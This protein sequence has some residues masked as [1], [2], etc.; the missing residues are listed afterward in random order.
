MKKYKSFIIW[1]ILSSVILMTLE[2]LKVTTLISLL[3]SQI[4]SYSLIFALI[5]AVVHSFRQAPFKIKYIKEN[6]LEFFSSV[7]FI[8]LFFIAKIIETPNTVF[9]LRALT[10]SLP[11]AI[12]MPSAK[13]VVLSV[14]VKDIFLLMNIYG[15]NR[16]VTGYVEK[17]VSNPAQT[18]AVSFI[19]VIIVGAL[20][21]MMDFTTKDDNGLSVL[22]ALFTATSCVCVT[23]LTVVDTATTFTVWGHLI[24]LMLIQIGGLGIMML[25]YFVIYAVS[26][27]VSLQ[28]KLMMSN[29]M[30]EDDTANIH[31]FIRNIVVTTFVIEFA[32]A[33]LL[34]FG[35]LPTLGLS[36]KTI[37]YAIFHSVSAFCNAGFAFYSDSLESFRLNPLITFTISFLI[38]LGGI[39]FS[40]ITNICAILDAKL[41]QIKDKKK[42]IQI[43]K[44]SVNTQVVF[45]VTAILL[46]SGTFIFYILEFDTTMKDYKLSEQYM[47]AFFQSVTFR[48]AGFNSVPF[49][50]LRPVTYI[51]FSLFM[52]IGGASGSTAGGI[53][54]NTLAV[55]FTAVR[56]F[57][58]GEKNYHLLNR[59]FEQEKIIQAMIISITTLAIIF[60]SVTIITI[61][62]NVPTERVLF[63][64]CSAIGTVGVT[65]GIT[66]SLSV[67]SKLILIFLMFWG[68]VGALTILSAG[69][70]EDSGANIRWPQA[71]IAIG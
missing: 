21:L 63:E 7:L 30:G 11:F 47:A 35:F 13:I 42:K 67:F 34:F 59:E 14:V 1:T 36:I 70:S 31:K 29:M 4:I 20:L 33:V 15:K 28:G 19:A 6:W 53:K 46:V 71:D 10:T 41:M 48:T 43:P 65:A 8:L 69:D 40:S 17:M 54:V 32:G 56:T 68:R 5:Y 16:Q 3:A 45:I 66:P 26:R 24:L 64:V 38:I 18:V 44:F 39:G 62:E 25:S 12:S 2:Q 52:I 57:K 23:G 49:D 55:L 27:R 50:S 9:F 61:L 51:I 37:W 60:V 58:R 22:Q